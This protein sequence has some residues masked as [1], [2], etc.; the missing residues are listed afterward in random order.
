MKFSSI[1]AGAFATLA[2]AVPAEKRNQ[3]NNNNN[4]N[5]NLLNVN[6]NNLNQFQ[7]GLNSF[8][9]LDVNNNIVAYLIQENVEQLALSSL[10][11][12]NQNNGLN[13]DLFSGLF[14]NNNNNNN[15]DLQNLALFAQLQMLAQVAATGALNQFELQSLQLQ[16]LNVG[17]LG[18]S[19]QNFNVESLV[20]SEIQPQILAVIEQPLSIL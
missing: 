19:F 4:N 5:N 12:L 10:F 14:Q 13:I 1:V 16:N 20:S 8:N 15:F 7:G 11:S 3:N 6:L 17:L 18:N 2:A 9:N